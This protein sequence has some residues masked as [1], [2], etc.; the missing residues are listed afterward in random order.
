[1]PQV[2]TD[3]DEY[4]ASRQN[5]FFTANGETP[6]DGDLTGQC[7][8]LVKWFLA[9]MTEVPLPFSARGDARYVG[10]TLVAQGHAVEVKYAERQEGDIIC[11]EF[12]IY[13]HIATQLSGGRVFEENVNL[14]GVSRRLVN[15]D[16]VYA[17]RIGSENEA[18]RADKNPH[19]YRIKTYQGGD[20]NMQPQ[21][22]EL[23]RQL[24]QTNKYLEE[25]Q[26]EVAELTKQL[27][28]T[29][30]YVD[31]LTKRVTTLEAGSSTMPADGNYKLTKLV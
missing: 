11:Y 8:T 9:E 20:A 10:H 4:A 21:I 12:G 7:V 27:D 5:I 3:A 23:N 16:Y 19:V 22:D 1:M 15:G 30:Q 2:A 26:K 14:G 29:N 18:W 17:S 13:G 28:S 6:A 31:K 25:T 24:N